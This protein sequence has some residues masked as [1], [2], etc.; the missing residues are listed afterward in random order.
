MKDKNKTKAQVLSEL[1]ELRQ[2]LITLEPANNDRKY[3]APTKTLERSERLY[4]MLAENVSDVIWTM[5]MNLRL[6]YI[7]PSVTRL[8]GFSVEEAMAKGGMDFLT[9]SSYQIAM[10][11]IAEEMAREKLRQKDLS[12]SRS[13]E[14]ELTC[15]DNSTIWAEVKMSF[16]RDSEGHP[17]G[18]L[19]VSRDITQRKQAEQTLM[20]SEQKYRTLFDESRD[21]IYIISCEG[22]F[23][24]NHVLCLFDFP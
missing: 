11:N 18:I 21:A 13:L 15:K 9:P 5:D 16:L 1:T 14:L 4:R 8:L 6:T 24:K 22:K 23:G 3:R 10:T 19:G 7:S 12:R 2:R 20:E 17:I